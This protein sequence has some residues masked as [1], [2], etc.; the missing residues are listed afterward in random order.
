MLMEQVDGRSPRPGKTHGWNTGKIKLAQKPN[1]AVQ[2]IAIP[3][4]TLWVLTS[5]TFLVVK[6]S[7]SHHSVKNVIIEMVSSKWTANS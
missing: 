4:T 5:R 7:T 2:R 1:V 6:N 3:K